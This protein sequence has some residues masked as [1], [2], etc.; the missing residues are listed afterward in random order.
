MTVKDSGPV[1]ISRP[2]PGEYAPFYR[3]YIERVPD[4]PLL[5]Q[6]AR[7]GEETRGWLAA[8]SAE[9][10]RYRYAPD[11]W[12]VTEVVGHVCDSERVFAY[13]A[14]RIARGDTTPLPGFDEKAWMGAASFDGRGLPDV[15]AELVAVRQATLALLRGLD[16][17]AYV[18]TGVANDTPVSVRALAHII[19]GHE[20]H[21]LAVL[22]ERYGVG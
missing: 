18:R 14:L 10:A 19:A 1:V 11:K 9:K 22:R 20:L 2:D 16:Q 8:L 17:A 21:H 12:S 3:G 4:R 15:L 5:E 7:Q 13:R 6:L